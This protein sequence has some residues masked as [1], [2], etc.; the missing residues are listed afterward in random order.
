MN[1]DDA[2]PTETDERGESTQRTEIDRQEVMAPP[3]ASSLDD[4][5]DKNYTYRRRCPG[6][7]LR[8]QPLQPL[9]GGHTHSRACLSSSLWFLFFTRMSS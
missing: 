4:E 7:C 2:P 8:A 6:G 9:S 1:P 3:I 5:K